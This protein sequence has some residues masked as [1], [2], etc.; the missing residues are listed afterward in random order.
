MSVLAQEKD[1]SADSRESLE[2]KL[3]RGLRVKDWSE[4][5]FNENGEILWKIYE[6]AIEQIGRAHV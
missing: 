6:Y 1:G 2:W 4:T 3:I 5:E